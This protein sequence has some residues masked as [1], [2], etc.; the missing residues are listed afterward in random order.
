MVGA[1]FS[2]FDR[3]LARAKWQSSRH[4]R[5]RACN[6]FYPWRP[7]GARAKRNKMSQVFSFLGSPNSFGM[8]A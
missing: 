6:R 2:G 1:M 8:S 4:R 5:A 7:G 3:P